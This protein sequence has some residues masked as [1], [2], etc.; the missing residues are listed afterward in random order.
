MNIAIVRYNAGNIGS[1]TNALLRMGIEPEVTSDPE[2][3]RTADKVIFPGVGEASS[4]MKSLRENGL[5]RLIPELKRPVLCICLGMQLLCERSEENSTEC[6]GIVPA[7][8][9]KFDSSRLKV[10]HIGWNTI[11]ELEGPLFEG[12]DERSHFYFVHG[13]FVEECVEAA[14]VCDY[15][16]NFTAALRKDNFFATQF[17]PEKSGPLGERVLRNFVEM[18]DFA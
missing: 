15:G 3:L 11:G 16:G 1:V 13:F 12:I 9:R 8:V 14:A 5:D 10:P 4:A 17:H 6:L 2:R 18:E 7:W